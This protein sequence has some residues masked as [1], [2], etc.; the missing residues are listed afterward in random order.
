[1]TVTLDPAVHGRNSHVEMQGGI[2]NG[3]AVLLDQFIDTVG[4]WFGTFSHI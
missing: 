2:A 4:P 3:P 1:M